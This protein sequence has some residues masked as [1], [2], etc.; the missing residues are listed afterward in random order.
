MDFVEGLP[1]VKE[2][3]AI[4]VVVDRLSNYGHFIPI[5]HPYT[6]SQ[7]ADL[8]IREVFKLHGMPQTIVS[9]KDPTF[10]SQFWT[11]FF[12][13]QGTKLCHSSAYHPQSDG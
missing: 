11:S 4:L 5:K 1:S 9:D 10:A 2:K 8:F 7:V 3:N 13:R 12:A 6:A